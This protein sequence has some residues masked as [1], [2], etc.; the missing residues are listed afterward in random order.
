MTEKSPKKNE[1]RMLMH[2]DKKV[3]NNFKSICAIN[4]TPMSTVIR[5]F[6]E[7]CIDNKTIKVC[8]EC[9]DKKSDADEL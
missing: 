1:I 8:S 7:Y 6:M 9:A 5:E 4:E 3:K 2:I